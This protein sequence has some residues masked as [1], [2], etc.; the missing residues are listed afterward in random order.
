MSWDPVSSISLGS[1]WATGQ[2][3]SGPRKVSGGR[4]FPKQGSGC[5]WACDKGPQGQR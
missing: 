4:G 3:P 1:E 5:Q 2:R